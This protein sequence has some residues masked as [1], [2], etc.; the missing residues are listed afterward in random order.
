MEISFYQSECGD[1]ARISFKGNDAK[2]HHIFIDA[3]YERTFRDCIR[4]DI[5]ELI[6]NDEIIDYWIVSHIHDDHIGGV[7]KYID[8]IKTGELKDIVENWVYNAPRFDNQTHL[9][10][11][12]ISEAKSIG[13]GDI[14]YNYLIKQNKKPTINYTNDSDSIDIFGLKI[15]FLSPT[16]NKLSALRKKYGLLKMKPFELIESDSISEAVAADRHD[17]HIK[18]VDFDLNNWEE[19]DSIENGSS[20]SFITEF[21]GKNIL[22]LADS[23]P[24]DI[25]KS[26]IKLGYSSENKL[27][28]EWVKITHHG[29][30]GNNNNELYDLIECENFLVS[31]NGENNAKL[32]TKE[33][34]T[35]IIR[36]QHRNM[37][38][39]YRFYFTYDNVTLKSIFNIDT[40]DI[41]ERYNFENVY[42]NKKIN[43]FKIN[44]YN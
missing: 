2:N 7:K 43:R 8:Y 30:K 11:S 1:A 38:L 3:G 10:T 22:W 23:H 27:K 44:P 16:K 35:R 33:A 19:D 29:S 21:E 24:S 31:A 40:K 6:K 41:Y 14:L 26:L 15:I 20:I 34:L 32:P 39:K 4:K 25:V 18:V 17:Y 36:N 28:C 12:V 37:N 42:L 5:E 9:V 13:Q